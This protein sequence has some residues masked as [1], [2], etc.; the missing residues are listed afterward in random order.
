LPYF[1]WDD[2]ATSTVKGILIL[3]RKKYAVQ[4]QNLALYKT[5]IKHIQQQLCREIVSENG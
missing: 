3:G 2:T 1:Y 4:G 5:I